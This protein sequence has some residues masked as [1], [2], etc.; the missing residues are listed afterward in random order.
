MKTTFRQR[1]LQG[2]LLSGIFVTLGI[3]E[4]GEILAASGFDWL[5]IDTEHAPLSSIHVQRII[6]GTANRCASLVRIS[7]ASEIAVKQALDTGAD[8]IIVPLVNSPEDA[9]Q[10]V[11][12]A[13]YAPEGSRGVGLARAHGY[14]KD[15]AQ[16]MQR[17]N[18]ETVVV[19]QAEQRQAVEQIQEIAAVPGLDGVFVGPYDLSASLGHPGE[20]DHPEVTGAIKSIFAACRDAGKATGVFGINAAAVRPFIQQGFTLVAAGVDTMVLG[21]AATELCDEMKRPY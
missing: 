8:G 12:W 3:P 2:E 7:S 19:V 11:A 14:G 9:R 20:V 5:C 15:F 16:Y 4:C 1:L 18:Q 10:V 6:Q 13:R 17:A 21:T